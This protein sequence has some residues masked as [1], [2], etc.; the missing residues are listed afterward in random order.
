MLSYLKPFQSTPGSEKVY[1]YYFQTYDALSRMLYL[2]N[3]ETDTTFHLYYI[4]KEA[5]RGKI[6]YVNTRG[7]VLVLALLID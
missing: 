3:L 7:F 2:G 4:A 5:E 6:K 1:V